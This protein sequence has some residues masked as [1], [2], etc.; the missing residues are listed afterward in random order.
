MPQLQPIHAIRYSESDT[1]T[2][3]SG[4]L[5]TL[6]APPYD[7][8]DEGPKQ[9]LLAVNPHNI[10]A[11]DL[12]V[13]PPK[14]VGPDEAYD[15]AGQTFRQWLADGILRHDAKPAV[16][17]YE[18]RYRLGDQTIT[19][20][21]L[22]ANLAVEEFGRNGGGIHRHEH[23]IRSGTDDRL[24]LMNATAAQLSPVFGVYDDEARRVAGLLKSVYSRNPDFWGTTQHDGVE[25]RGWIITERRKLNALDRAFVNTDVFIADGHHRYTTALNYSHA[26][27]DN[28]AAK[29]CLFVL[30]PTGD[31]GLRVLPTHRVLMGLQNFSMSDLAAAVA[32]DPRLRLAR[33]DHAGDGLPQLQHE[34]PEHG[35]HA[36]GLYDPATGRTWTLST[37]EADPLAA[38]MPDKARVWRELDVA[39]FHHLMVDQLIRPRFGGDA[40]TYKYPHELT[41]LVRLSHEQPGRL[42]VVMQPTP[43]KSV[44]DVALAGE[45]MPPKSTFFF[46]KLATGLIINPLD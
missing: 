23:T 43:L 14:T 27:P 39:V 21:G 36:V 12:P 17:A 10:V 30:V 28:A 34:L 2:G 42:G 44:C 46:P 15:R 7:V 31:P 20:R 35:H 11:I 13:T 8:L 6:I 18:Q 24:K 38:S 40:V 3:G 37:A 19:R 1:T 26:H 5:S 45:V 33:T 32:A 4:D 9:Q 16:F 22:F 41:E 25:H 29:T